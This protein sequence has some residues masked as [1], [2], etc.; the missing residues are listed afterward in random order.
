MDGLSGSRAL[1]L[2]AVV[3]AGCA[4]LPARSERMLEEPQV[5]GL[6]PGIE[7]AQLFQRLGP[8]A[9]EGAYPN[10][11]ESVASWRLLEP[12]NRRML[13]NA[14]FDPSGRAK[15]YSRTL[16]PAAV[17]GESPSGM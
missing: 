14:H 12:G 9:E 6:V 7:R 10:L 5:A 17:D 11:N 3:C 15:Y 8:P 1:L 4:G 13:F 2:I 16:D